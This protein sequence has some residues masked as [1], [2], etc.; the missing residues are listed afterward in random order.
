MINSW[1]KR[2]ANQIKLDAVLESHYDDLY[3]I[4]FA[5]AQDGNLAQDLVQETML[6]ALL[7][8]DQ[9]NSFEHID[10][11]LCKIMHHLFYDHC[12]YD[13]RWQSVQVEDADSYFQTESVETLYLKKQTIKSIHD[14]IGCLPI[15][16]REVLILVDLQGYSYIE[17]ADIVAVPVGTIMSRL[18][19]A[20]SKLR[21]L[22]SSEE[23]PLFN[24]NNVVEITLKSKTK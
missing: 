23:N 21:S 9:I 14:A 6:K 8:A 3:R 4:A 18:S 16:Q 7:K 5:W 24:E 11:W 2:K 13:N 22:I 20:R 1:I 17:V 15:D 10:R 12:R 19:R